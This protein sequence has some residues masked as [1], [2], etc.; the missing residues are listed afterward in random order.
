MESHRQPNLLGRRCWHP[1]ALTRKVSQ[2]SSHLHQTVLIRSISLDLAVTFKPM[3][4]F[5]F[6]DANPAI[7]SPSVPTPPHASHSTPRKRDSAIAFS[8]LDSE[9]KRR[10]LTSSQV[11]PISSSPSHSHL[12]MR[13]SSD[14]SRLAVK[15][16]LHGRR[17]RRVESRP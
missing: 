3:D 1:S 8:P 4:F 14:I 16:S 7:T 6:A 17:I 11:S 10:R 15:P 2:P 9:A 5:L 12:L 13:S